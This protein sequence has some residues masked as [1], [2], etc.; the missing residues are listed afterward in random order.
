MEVLKLLCFL[1]SLAVVSN[2]LHRTVTLSSG[3]ITKGRNA[4]DITIQ[5]HRGSQ[6]IIWEKDFNNLKFYFMKVHE[7]TGTL[8][9]V[10]VDNVCKKYKKESIERAV[11]DFF[12]KE[13]AKTDKCPIKKGKVKISYPMNFKYE[14]NDPK[15]ACGPI[16]AMYNIIRKNQTNSDDNPLLMNIWYQGVISGDGCK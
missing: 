15:T 2:A 7:V 12:L 8:E 1:T 11:N 6:E 14:I 4:S 3:Y 5:N 9:A 16:I 13:L 10:T